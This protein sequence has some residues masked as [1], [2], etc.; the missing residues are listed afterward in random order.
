MLIDKTFHLQETLP[1]EQADEHA[2]E[3][4]ETLQEET[5]PDEQADEQVESDS[6]IVEINGKKYRETFNQSDGTTSLGPLE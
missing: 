4:E 3:Q 2:D 5:L 1:D 6:K